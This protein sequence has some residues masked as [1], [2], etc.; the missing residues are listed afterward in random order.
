M[1]S[2]KRGLSGE[3][4]RLIFFGSVLGIISLC[5]PLALYPEEGG[6]ILGR[7]FDFLTQNFGVLY[8]AGASFT[9]AFLLYLAF[10]RHGD[11]RLGD[12]SPE[13]STLSWAAMLFCGG[14]GTSVLYWGVVEWAYYFQAPPYGVTPATPEAMLWSV[15]YPLFHW[16]LMGWSLYVLPG[17]AIAYSYYVRGAKSLRLSDAC[18]PVIGRH[19]KGALGRGIDLLFVVGLVGACSIGIGLAVPLI[20]ACVAHLLQ[21]DRQSLGFTLDVVVILVV[22]CI[23]AG[24]VWMGLERGIKRLSDLNVML[25]LVLLA[26]ILIAGPTLFIVELGLEG[27]GH[28]LQNFVRMSTY[29]DAAGTTNFVE[30]WTVF[31]WAWWLA[32]G[33]YMGV[34]ITKISQGRTLRELILG[35]LGYG[36]LGCIVFFAILGNYALYLEMNQLFPVID[37]LN[38]AGAPAAIVGVLGT[39]PLSSFAI[40]IFTLVCI[41]FAATSYDSAS[42]TLAAS[43]TKS[44]APEDHPDRGHRVFWAFL[45]GLLPITLVYMGGLKPLQ[46]AVTLA[47]VPLYAV[48]VILTISLWRSIHAAEQVSSGAVEVSEAS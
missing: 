38:S 48:T 43:A 22:T 46:S 24:S 34:F 41:I 28:M 42:Y 1:Q 13:F 7:A 11:I 23:F 27:V 21:V 12:K 9:F 17:V 5:V 25:A 45:L 6:A 32:L 19:A 26:F 39:L 10:S 29:T 37:T 14:I 33:P 36:T 16:G 31:Y 18:E 44:L 35:G 15:S 47:S 2:S 40:L 30:A 20:G 8:V 4:D 3:L